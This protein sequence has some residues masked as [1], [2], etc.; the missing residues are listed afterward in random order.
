MAK[1]RGTASQLADSPVLAA[2]ARLGYAAGGLLH[3]V[4]GWIAVNLAWGSGGSSGSADQS[5]AL[6]E[7]ASTPVGGVLL[8]VVVVGFAL[9]A[10]WQ[11]TE[12]VTAGELEEKGQSAAKFVVY[13]ALTGLAASIATGSGSGGGGSEQTTSLTARVMQHPLGVLAVALVGAGIVGVGVFHVV[14]GWRRTFLRDLR[15]D[16]GRA[17]TLAGR[18]GYVAK[19]SRSGWSGCSSS[20]RP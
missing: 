10:L 11:V 18:V 15:E 7:L 8:W 17:V 5:G 19:G 16:P 12:A 4:M 6:A 9:L 2:G 3:L 13:L 20:S 14:K 1:V